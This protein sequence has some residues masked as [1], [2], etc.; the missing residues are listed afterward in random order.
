MTGRWLPIIGY[1]AV[2]SANQMLWLTFAPITT[3]AAHHYHVSVS[4][5]GWLAE[6]FPFLYVLLALPSGALLDRRFRPGLATGAV[7]TA[8]GALIRLLGNGF[9]PVLIGQ[10]IIALAQPLVLN[11]VTKLADDYLRAPDRSTGIAVSSASIFG[12]MVLALLLGALLGEHRIPTLL[13]IQAVY[14]VLAA[15][16]LCFAVR[17]PG[18][19]TTAIPDRV[20]VRIVWADPYLRRLTVMVFA[21]FGVF[22]ALTTW[23]QALLEPAGVTES[24]AGVLLLVMVLAGVLGSATLPPWL[25]RRGAALRFV[26]VSVLGTAAGCIALAA[27][28]G[29]ATGLIVTLLVGFLL[30]TDLPVILELAAARGG[31][32]TG[33]ATG[34][35]WLSGNAGGLIVAGAVQTL[36]HYPAA[37]FCLL[38]AVVF[39]ALPATLGLIRG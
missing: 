31:P 37:A 7:L 11:S 30:L 28:P 20:G 9:G 29:L 32:A 14:A 3:G 33:T 26:A 13:T 35:L 16:L 10:I 12:G 36:V 8:L 19:H 38:A 6:V 5:I 21:G 39:V 15:L 34:L 4:T 22:V 23:L 25:G 18:A 27:A 24:T 1:A 2:G 17:R